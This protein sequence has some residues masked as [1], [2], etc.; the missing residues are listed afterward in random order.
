METKPSKGLRVKVNARR[1]A[2]FGDEAVAVKAVSLPSDGSS[3]GVLTGFTLAG[4][5]EVEMPGLD[6]KKHWY[7]VGDLQGENGEPLVEEEIQIDE[8]GDEPEGDE[9]E[10]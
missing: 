6:G 2:V 4:Y 8:A 5:C 9:S 1:E 3:T 10:E 7:P